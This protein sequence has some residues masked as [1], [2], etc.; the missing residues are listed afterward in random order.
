MCLEDAV[1][2]VNAL[3]AALADGSTSL[4]SAADISAIFATT[5]AARR[6]RVAAATDESFLAQ[7][8]H[9]LATLPFRLLALY[10]LLSVGFDFVLARFTNMARAAPALD[11]L[12][13]PPRPMLVG[14]DDENPEPA[15]WGKRAV[16]WGAALALAGLA[17]WALLSPDS[18]AASFSPH[19]LLHIHAAAVLA[20]TLVEGW[21]RSAKLD[22]AQWPLPWA[23]AADALGV[24]RVLPLFLLLTYVALSARGRLTYTGLCQ[25]V[26]LSAARTIAPVVAAI[27][28][29]PAAVAFFQPDSSPARWAQAAT[30]SWHPASQ[31][32]FLATAAAALVHL[33]SYLVAPRAVFDTAYIKPVQA[34]YAALAIVLAAAHG[35]TLP[36]LLAAA[37]STT[38]TTLLG[39]QDAATLAA[40][41]VFAVATTCDA[42]WHLSPRASTV[43]VC[44]RALAVLGAC[45]VLGP[46]AALVGVWFWRESAMARR[47][48]GVLSA[49]G[50][51]KI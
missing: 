18:T 7:K 33:A 8:L 41:V 16:R 40:I 26:I 46:G 48:L 10:D 15:G 20:L 23:F 43:R 13:V 31:T 1:V 44:A 27:C 9:A 28:I 25:P 3:T 45:V 39:G 32:A 34:T 4:L 5:Q 2:F 36:W 24:A 22:V 50:A 14:F 30:E 38:T 19:S 11:A 35:A 6:P 29:L 47:M 12:D 37:P 21:R 42:S 49:A 17:V 51:S